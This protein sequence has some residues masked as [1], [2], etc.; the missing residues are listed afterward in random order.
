VLK[1]SFFSESVPSA[2]KAALI[3]RLFGVAEATPLQNQDFFSTLES[4]Y[5]SS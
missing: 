2:A 5:S 1:K 3:S 4:A